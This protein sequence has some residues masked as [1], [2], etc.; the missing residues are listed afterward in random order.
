MKARVAECLVFGGDCSSCGDRSVRKCEAMNYVVE[1]NML[2]TTSGDSGEDCQGA[3][4]QK[5]IEDRKLN[6]D[7]VVTH[8]SSFVFDSFRNW[9][10]LKLL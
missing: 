3:V 10:P 5:I 2:L 6:C 9:E 1:A 4:A 7:S 8:A